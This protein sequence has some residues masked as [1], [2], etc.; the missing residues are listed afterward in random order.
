VIAVKAA[1]SPDEIG[2]LG[3]EREVVVRGRDTYLQLQQ[4]DE[5][6]PVDFAIAENGR[7]EARADRLTR[8]DRD[9]GPTAVG[10]TKEVIT[11]SVSRM[12]YVQTARG[13][14]PIGYTLSMG[15]VGDTVSYRLVN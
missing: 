2:R 11:C 13:I 10:V 5:F 3:S 12:C 6:I 1:G 8:V 4:C 7:E 15:S 14:T 9:N